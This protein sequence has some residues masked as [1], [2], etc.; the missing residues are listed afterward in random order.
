MCIY[1]ITRM[2]TRVRMLY[3]YYYY[4]CQSPVISVFDREVVIP[5]HGP[6]AVSLQLDP[7]NWQSSIIMILQKT[8]HRSKAFSRRNNNNNNN[9]HSS[10]CYSHTFFTLVHTHAHTQRYCNVL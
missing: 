3:D 4:Y 7:N 5:T 9:T 6:D 1:I 2:H 8:L 10:L